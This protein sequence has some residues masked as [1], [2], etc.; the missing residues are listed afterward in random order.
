MSWFDFLEELDIVN[1]HN[2]SIKGCLDEW[3]DGM[4]LGNK[5]RTGLAWEDDENY[6]IL[7]QDKYSGEFIFLILK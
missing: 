4:Q 5:L 2:G 3:C 7:Q 6:P 1:Q